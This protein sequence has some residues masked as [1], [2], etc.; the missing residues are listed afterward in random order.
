MGGPRGSDGYT[1]PGRVSA[2][3]FFNVYWLTS[4]ITSTQSKHFL[5]T[6]ATLPDIAV[7]TI[8]STILSLTGAQWTFIASPITWNRLS[9]KIPRRT[10]MVRK[11]GS[12]AAYSSGTRA[13]VTVGQV[14]SCGS[15]AF[16]ENECAKWLVQGVVEPM[17]DIKISR[18]ARNVKTYLKRGS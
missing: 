8:S 11:S 3:V 13:W 18:R 6:S 4:F 9:P 5:R 14:T 17:R 7:R 16:L 15:T 12:R 2:L 1:R 10:L